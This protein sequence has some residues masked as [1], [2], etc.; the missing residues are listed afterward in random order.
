MSAPL[1]ALAG[2][3]VAVTVYLVARQ[4]GVSMRVPVDPLD[5]GTP[6]VPIGVVGVL[7]S[8]VFPAFAGAIV[9]AL[10]SRTSRPLTWFLVLAVVLVG[11][12]VGP[13]LWGRDPGMALMDGS[14]RSALATMHVLRALVVV[15]VLSRAYRARPPGA[16]A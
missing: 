1:A 10:V 3:A 12:S 8:S 14:T 4:A 13:L 6:M 15:W 5:P 2:A 16:G 7:V 9:L 11:A